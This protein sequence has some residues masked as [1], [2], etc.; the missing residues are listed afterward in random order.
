MLCRLSIQNLSTT[1]GKSSFYGKVTEPSQIPSRQ[2]CTT[3]AVTENAHDVSPSEL[4]AQ[5]LQLEEAQVR[6]QCDINAFG[7]HSTDLQHT[8][9]QAQENCIQRKI[10]A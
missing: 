2:L 8:K 4:I 5:G 7:L 1:G 10:E 6:L 3:T 9:V